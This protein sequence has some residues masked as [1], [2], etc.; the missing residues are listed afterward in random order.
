MWGGNGARGLAVRDLNHDALPDVAGAG[1]LD[2]ELMLFEN[3]VPEYS[4]DVRSWPTSIESPAAIAFADLDRDAWPDVAVATSGTSD[5]VLWASS[6]APHA[7]FTAYPPADGGWVLEPG[8]QELVLRARAEHLGR[9]DDGDEEVAALRLQLTDGAGS[10][11]TTG[12]ANALIADLLVVADDG[13]GVFEPGLDTTIAAVTNLVL[14]SQGRLTVNLPDG[15]PL[16]QVP[17]GDTG[18][19]LY[20]A[21]VGGPGE[22]RF[23]VGLLT[24]EGSRVEDRDYDL[25]LRVLPTEPKWSRVWELTHSLIFAD[26]FASGST[27]AW[28]SLAP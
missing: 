25:P 12:E 26:G 16:L 7:K 13:D 1:P 22:G 11:L 8:Q 27:G 5:S 2:D 15:S 9:A 20:V 4:W 23:Q 19:Y 3:H 14:D 17:G 21:V 18:R 6:C 10:A 24:R 28:S